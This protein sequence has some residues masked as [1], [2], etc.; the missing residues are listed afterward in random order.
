MTKS[1]GSAFLAQLFLPTSAPVNP[2]NSTD[3]STTSWSCFC[4]TCI[5]S[6]Y[7]FH[8]GSEACNVCSSI[9]SYLK[10]HPKIGPLLQPVD[11]A[12][13]HLYDYFTVITH[14]MDVS[15]VE[16]NLVDGKYSGVSTSGKQIE[17]KYGEQEDEI[18]SP[19]YR[20]VYNGGFYN[21]IMLIFD[22]CIKYNGEQSWIGTRQQNSKRMP[23]WKLR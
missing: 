23:T 22:N 20:M 21:D 7:E 8:Q 9:V 3:N 14:P 2:S 5:I 4:S 11:T 16:K 18:D 6:L 13:L 15:T 10:S 19:V 1:S 17:G 12:A